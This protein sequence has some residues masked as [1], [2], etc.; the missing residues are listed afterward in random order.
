MRQVMYHKARDMLRKAKLAKNG[1]CETILERWSTDALYQ[2]SLS[3]EGWTGEKIHP[4]HQ[5][6]H[7]S[8]QQFDEYEENAYTVHPRTGWR[9]HPSTSS[10]SPTQWQQKNEWK[11]NQ[12]WDYSGSCF[13]LQF[14]GNRRRVWTEH[15]VTLHVQ[16]WTLCP[17]ST[18]HWFVTRSRVAQVVLSKKIV[19]PSIVPRH[20]SQ[21]AQYTQQFHLNFTVLCFSFAHLLRLKVDHFGNTLRRFTR[22]WRWRFYGSRT[23]HKIWRESLTTHKGKGVETPPPK[24]RREGSRTTQKE[25]EGMQHHSEKGGEKHHTSE[26]KE[27]TPKKP[28]N[29][30][31]LHFGQ[32][33]WNLWRNYRWQKIRMILLV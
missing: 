15:C 20:L 23:S 19:M 27:G 13:S 16:T 12:S 33:S 14:P 22:P 6:R 18:L 32:V 3:D 24:G 10:S 25:E 1:S 26:R 21:L 7:N 11:S 4:A 28:Q 9:F 8:Q 5:R 2:K 29:S 30:Q 17:H 31:N